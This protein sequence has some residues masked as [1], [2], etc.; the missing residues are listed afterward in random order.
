PAPPDMTRRTG[1]APQSIVI[2]GGGAA[3]VAAAEMIR[4]QGYDGPVTMISADADPPV[5]RPNLSKDYL[6][7]E[8]QEDWIHL[9]PPESYVARRLG[10]ASRAWHWRRRRCA[11]EQAARARHRRGGWPV[12]PIAARSAGRCLAAGS[13]GDLGRRAEGEP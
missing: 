5:D 1:E 2:V 9:W 12:R 10:R 13:D 4:R 3:G 11:R 6:A 8:A 7:G